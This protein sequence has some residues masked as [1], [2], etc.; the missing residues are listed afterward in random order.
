MNFRKKK[1]C[2]FT[3]ALFSILSTYG[4]TSSYQL[5]PN[6]SLIPTN[7]LIDT[8][9]YDCENLGVATFNVLDHGID[10]SGKTDCTAAVQR[11]LDACGGVKTYSRGD[12]RNSAGGTLYFPAGTYLFTGQIIIPR[13]VSIRGDWNEQ[14]D[15][16]NVAK[17]PY[18]I[19]GNEDC[20]IVN[21]AF[22]AVYRGLDL[23]TNKCDRH[24]VDYLAGHAFA[25]VVRIGGNSED[26]A[27]TNCQFN[28]IVYACGD[29]TKFGAWPNSLAMKDNTHQQ[30]AYCQ[31]ERDLN[32]LIV[33]DCNREF[34]YNNFLF[35]C[36]KGM[37]FIAD[38]NGGARDC[39]SLGNAVDGA[40]QT[41]VFDGIS[42]NLNLVN[43]Q[44]VALDHD[45]EQSKHR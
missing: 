22:R 21:V 8:P 9:D 2:A 24:Y 10:N 36:A 5:A 23:F 26:G 17:Y 18:T 38:N 41:F 29:E 12:S 40:T 35:V 34:L 45:P 6:N 42:S 19:R 16:M 15:P 13:G 11:L 39:R 37:W 25:N 20:Y 7:K 28:T 43:S 32:F 3:V 1:L 14:K 31:N 27:F 4:D 33:G 30:Q 44:I